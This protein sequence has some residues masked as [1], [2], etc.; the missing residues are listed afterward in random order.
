[1]GPFRPIHGTWDFPRHVIP[2]VL[3]APRVSL[4]SCTRYANG[5]HPYSFPRIVGVLGDGKTKYDYAN[6]GDDQAVGACSVCCLIF[7]CKGH[8]TGHSSRLTSD[9]QMS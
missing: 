1:M 7:L 4:T 9:E 8:L 2:P 3:T 5:H 6:D